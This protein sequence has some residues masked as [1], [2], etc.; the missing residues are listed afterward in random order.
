MNAADVITK[1][2]DKGQ[3]ESA[4]DSEGREL[5]HAGMIKMSKSKNNGVDPQAIVEKYGA[6]TLRL[7]IMFAAPAEMA[8]EW[9]ESG[10]EGS[11]R[12][13]K[14]IW[15]LTQEHLEQGSVN[16]L[17]VE[18]LTNEQKKLRCALHKT[19]AKVTDD[20]D[21]RQSFNTA[22]A[23]IM[24]LVNQ[25]SKA[26]QESDNDRAIFDEFIKTTLTMLYPFTPHLSIELWNMLGETTSIEDIT[27]PTVDT[28]ALVE[29][30]KLIVV[31]VNGKVRTKLE[32][33]SDST[34]DYIERYALEQE[35]VQKFTA[36][37]TIRKVIYVPGKLL[38][39]VAN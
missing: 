1:K 5:T 19:I 10:V 37:K 15:K 23:A 26:P 18:Q 16:P 38:N 6:D 29:E 27:W 30:S 39:I 8:L 4:H 35:Q 32:V 34:Q 9:Q 28:S 11:H 25:F 33:A 36:D 20:I 12:F 24:E 13:I 21:R 22:I 14:R 2:N 31:Q 3:L 7:F 17:V